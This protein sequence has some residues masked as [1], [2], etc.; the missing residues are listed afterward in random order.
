MATYKTALSLLVIVLCL[1][2]MILL[3]AEL[4]VISPL[5][6]EVFDTFIYL[7]NFVQRLARCPLFPSLAISHMEAGTSCLFWPRLC[8]S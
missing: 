5:I 6:L 1:E 2:A 8:L 7:F 4:Q 3:Q